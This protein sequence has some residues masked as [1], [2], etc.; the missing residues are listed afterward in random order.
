MVANGPVLT[1]DADLPV[2]GHNQAPIERC[3]HRALLHGVAVELGA[4]RLVLLRLPVD[5]GAAQTVE[6]A[7]IPQQRDRH[8]REHHGR[9]DPQPLQALFVVFLLD[10][11]GRLLLGVAQVILPFFH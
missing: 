4:A 5:H 7:V 8:D 3:E 9:R 2:G 10:A 11:P 1:E 6:A